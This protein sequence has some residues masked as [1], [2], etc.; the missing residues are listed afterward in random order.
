M[1]REEYTKLQIEYGF[2][3]ADGT[4]ASPV[5]FAPLYIEGVA[6]VVHPELEDLYGV[7]YD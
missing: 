2:R 3:N 6:K 7:K 5:S 1:N 4:P